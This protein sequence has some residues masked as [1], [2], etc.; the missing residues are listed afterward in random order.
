MYQIRKN[1]HVVE[2]QDSLS[3]VKDQPNGILISCEESEGRG[4][5]CGA[6]VTDEE[7][8]TTFQKN[9]VIYSVVGKPQMREFDFVEIEEIKWYPIAEQQRADTDYIAIMTGVEL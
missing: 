2:L 9:S 1:G 8:V 6:H 5:L 7:G 4:I 3:W